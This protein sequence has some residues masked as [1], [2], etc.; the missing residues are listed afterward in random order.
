M[1]LSS[2]EDLA[3]VGNPNSVSVEEVERL[4]VKRKILT[5]GAN[6]DTEAFV[7]REIKR[8][9]MWSCFIIDRYL[10]SGRARPQMDVETLHIQLPC[11]ADDFRLGTNVKTEFLHLGGEPLQQDNGLRN[12][13][14]APFGTDS[15]LSIYIRLVEIWGRFSK[16]SCA[17][18]RRSDLTRTL[19]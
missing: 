15:D 16:W 19:H 12:R 2:E 10:S 4:G 9:T 8:R 14:F 5:P 13:Q 18:G 3:T 1:G 7:C 11:S 6:L 17:G